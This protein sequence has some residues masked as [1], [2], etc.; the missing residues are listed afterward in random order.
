[1][2]QLT[3]REWQ[4]LTFGSLVA[5]ARLEAQVTRPTSRFAGVQIGIQSYSLRDRDLDGVVAAMVEVG[6]N[7][8]ELWEGHVEPPALRRP[9]A[10]EALRRWRL[11][12][13]L[14]HFEQIRSQ[15]DRAG[16]ELSAYN[17]SFKDHFSDE[18][19]ARGFEMAA[20]LGVD[21]ITSSANMNSVYRIAP[22]ARRHGIAVAMH[23]H[24]R[25]DPNEFAT[26]D[27]FARA[28]RI[29]GDAPIAINLDIGH[30]TA[31]NLDPV[32][33]LRDHHQDIAT[34][35][36]KDRRREQGP[37]VPWGE[38]DTPIRKV[39]ALL[40]DERWPIP[41]NIEYEYRGDDTVT[42]IRR[43]LDYCRQALGA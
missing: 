37:N 2:R 34:I 9:E 23:N 30:F 21:V 13:P 32:A 43:C 5:A 18:E 15:V 6:L 25:I 20:A 1:M 11:T 29:G 7:S 10:R 14:A 41:A 8:C 24:S 39:L 36:L 28:M 4:T 16:L 31:A 33:F 19:I 35:H 40:R 3:R 26:P 38:G 22:L 42:E 27:D 12:V 17:L